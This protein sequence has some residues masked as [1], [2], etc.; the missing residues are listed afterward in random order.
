V[1]RAEEVSEPVEAGAEPGL[2]EVAVRHA[3]SSRSDWRALLAE[4]HRRHDVIIIDSP[5]VRAGPEPVLLGSFADFILIVV[6]A[7]YTKRMCLTG[8]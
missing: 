6:R 1:A 2:G 3:F 7:G 5:E 4:L 8:C